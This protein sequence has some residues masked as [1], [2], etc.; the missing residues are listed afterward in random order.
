MRKDLPF[1]RF[2]AAAVFLALAAYIAAAFADGSSAPDTVT[3][4]R[5]S[6]K[7]T[8]CA[9]GIV[10]RQEEYVT[11]P[12]ET[13]YLAVSEGERIKGGS[14]LFVNTDC[15]EDYLSFLDSCPDTPYG[16]TQDCVRAQCAGFFS[17]YLDGYESADV[18]GLDDFIPEIPADAVGR[19]VKNGWLFVFDTDDAE[20]FYEGQTLTLEIV[21][22]YRARVESVTGKRVVLRCREGLGA[23][24]CTRHLDAR[25]IIDDVCG[26]KL[27][28]SAIHSD[29]DGDTVYT[30][31]SGVEQVVPV[32]VIY[33]ED[34]YCLVKQ[35]KLCEGMA[36]IK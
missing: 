34:S 15:L 14:V 20:L 27:P 24:L 22:G 2:V 9:E 33:K 8:V 12:F 1:L 21:D 18:Y 17:S 29:A 30:L 6:V 13:A 10:L 25:L 4:V 35:D 16:N 7:K 23:V 31:V 28:Y 19:I 5:V 26:L 36:V 3:A 11:S 32:E